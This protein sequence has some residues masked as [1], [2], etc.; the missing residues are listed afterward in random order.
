M[1]PATFVKD[2]HNKDA[3]ELD[4][5]RLGNTD[6]VVSSIS[7]GGASFGKGLFFMLSSH[8]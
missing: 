8:L 5:R 2:F 7:L 1:E 4:Y 6:M 3:K